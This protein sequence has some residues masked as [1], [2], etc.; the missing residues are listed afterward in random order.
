MN[1]NPEEQF[2]KFLIIIVLV[3]AAIIYFIV[4]PDFFSGIN[5]K[6]GLKLSSQKPWPEE[7]ADEHDEIDDVEI[8]LTYQE[9]QFKQNEPEKEKEFNFGLNNDNNDEFWVTGSVPINPMS[10][11]NN[12]TKEEIYAQRKSFVENTIFKNKKYKPSEDVFGKIADNKPWLGIEALTCYG[13]GP[14][15]NK[16]LSEESR[17]IN[18]PT[19]LIGLDRVS[20]DE[21]PKS[22]CSAVDYLMP[23]KINYSKDENTIKVVFE[24]SGYKGD[25]GTEFLLKG[26]NAKD[27]GFKYAYANKTENVVFLQQDRNISTDVHM[28]KDFIQLGMVCGVK[29]GCNNASPFQKELN[30]TV[31]RYPATIHFKLWKKQPK[32]KDIK[33]DINYLIILK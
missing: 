28:F 22:M 8:Q 31:M 23:V 27:L 11:L 5:S 19:M 14:N 29:G 1:N 2:K 4:K 13:K 15:A 12:K 26:L 21:K 24:V 9:N 7:F 30:Y 6:S 16:G 32:N 20:F 17:Y 25:L 3:F 18:N 33:E 10:D